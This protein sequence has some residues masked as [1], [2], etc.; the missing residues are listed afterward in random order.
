MLPVPARR[1]Q[2]VP[3]VL[4][5]G[6]DGMSGRRKFCG[7]WYADPGAGGPIEIILPERDT[8]PGQDAR[9]GRAHRP[10]AARNGMPGVR[11]YTWRPG[12]AE[13]EAEVAA[14]LAAIRAQIAARD[15]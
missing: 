3:A 8:D 13:R 10:W 4:A 12:D 2:A 5:E 14:E 1:V 9:D 6:E 11:P 7:G 15:N